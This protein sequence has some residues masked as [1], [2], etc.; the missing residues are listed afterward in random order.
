MYMPRYQHGHEA[1]FVPPITGIHLAALTPPHYRVRVV[2]QQVQPID[3]DTDA[4]LI[5][6]TFF[7]GSPPAWGFRGKV[8]AIPG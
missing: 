4:D 2:H 7:T 8:N 5:A 1:N 6:L 3:F